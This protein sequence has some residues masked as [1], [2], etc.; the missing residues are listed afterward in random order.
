MEYGRNQKA[1]RAHGAGHFEDQ[2]WRKHVD[3]YCRSRGP[4]GELAVQRALPE[5]GLQREDE[6]DTS[7]GMALTLSVGFSGA[8]SAVRGSPHARRMR[9]VPSRTVG[10]APADRQHD[11]RALLTG[12]CV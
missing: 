9:L 4:S 6:R 5:A 3:D 8:R 12:S 7:S 1:A 11:R 2:A 10:V